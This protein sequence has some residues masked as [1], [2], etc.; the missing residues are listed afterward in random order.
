M[1]TMSH[2]TTNGPGAPDMLEEQGRFDGAQ[3]ISC[4]VR[5]STLG[6]VVSR[7]NPVDSLVEVKDPKPKVALLVW[8]RMNRVDF[9]RYAVGDHTDRAVCPLSQ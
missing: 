4:G 3:S 7:R 6:C 8:I 9:E 5:R 1:F 2:H